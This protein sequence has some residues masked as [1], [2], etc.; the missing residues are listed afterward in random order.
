[1]LRI[2]QKKKPRAEQGDSFTSAAAQTPTKTYQRG[3]FDHQQ[4]S[5]TR[6]V[7]GSGSR[8]WRSFYKFKRRS[9]PSYNIVNAMESTSPHTNGDRQYHCHRIQQWHNEKKRTKAMDMR[10]YWIKDRVKQGQFNV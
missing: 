2:F 8:N 4:S 9:S 3:N 6:N 7:F 5:Q 10:F 1:M